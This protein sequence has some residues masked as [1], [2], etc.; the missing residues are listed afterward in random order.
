MLHFRSPVSRSEKSLRF[1]RLA[2]WK[3]RPFSDAQLICRHAAV[4]SKQIEDEW[5]LLQFETGQFYA[6]EDVLF[7][8]WARLEVPTRFSE[9]VENLCKAF[10]VDDQTCAR[11]VREL[12]N[13]LIRHRLVVIAAQTRDSE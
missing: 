5:L 7:A 4:I 9:L 3:P 6:F 12:L 1:N 11:D 2:F 10:D 8:M 13:E